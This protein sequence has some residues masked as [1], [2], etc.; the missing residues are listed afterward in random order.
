MIPARRRRC[1][2]AYFVPLVVPASGAFAVLA[3]FLPCFLCFLVALVAVSEV[4]A[5]FDEPLACVAAKPAIVNGAANIPIISKV[6]N[7][8][9]IF[10]S[11]TG[12]S[13]ARLSNEMPG[14]RKAHV[15]FIG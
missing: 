2:G 1:G 11:L 14:G 4:A 10:S 6:P 9:I 7:F 15:A 3:L 5:G 8:F 13:A 12:L